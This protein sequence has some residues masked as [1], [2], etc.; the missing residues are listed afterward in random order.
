MTQEKN[1]V[2]DILQNIACGVES[3]NQKLDKLLHES[4]TETIQP[5]KLLSVKEVSV[6]LRVTERTV[7]KRYYEGK[8]KSF[9]MGGNRVFA[10]S[11]VM[12]FLKESQEK[13]QLNNKD[14]KHGKEILQ[15]RQ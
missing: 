7:Y 3:A 14:A 5:D 1:N 4:H 15:T 10:Y 13:A 12:R 11:E 8:L 9:K 2:G 6:L